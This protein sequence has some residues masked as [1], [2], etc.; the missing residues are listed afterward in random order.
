MEIKG[1][2]AGGS[3]VWSLGFLGLAAY[4]RRKGNL[5]CGRA[6]LLGA[7]NRWAPMECWD[8]RIAVPAGKL[9]IRERCS[10]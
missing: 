5:F 9:E 2:S 7:L 4:R 6:G 3:K 10:C 1:L 8:S